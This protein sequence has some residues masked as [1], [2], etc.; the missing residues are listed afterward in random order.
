MYRKTT[1]LLA[2]MLCLL[3]TVS[4]LFAQQAARGGE[5]RCDVKKVQTAKKCAQ[6]NKILEDKDLKD[7]KCAQCG[8]K[9]VSVS[10]CVK[11]GFFC[12]KCDFHSAKK[13]ACQNCKVALQEKVVKAEVT[14]QCP[15]CKETSDKAGGCPKCKKTLER[16]CKQS[17]TFP[18]VKG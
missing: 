5:N 12:N 10:V 2:S 1:L 4:A 8:E 17:G 18:H 11:S 7:G 13:G 14:Y 16:T 15:G 3:G 6:C 9:P